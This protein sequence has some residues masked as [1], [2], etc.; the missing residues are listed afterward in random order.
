MDVV[1]VVTSPQLAGPRVPGQARQCPCDAAGQP[2]PTGPCDRV[3]APLDA[4]LAALA[5]LRRRG[6]PTGAVTVHGDRLTV[7]L[8]PGSAED[9]PDLL[10]WLGWG[11]LD[12]VLRA[13]RGCAAPPA[14][15]P[16]AAP[17]TAPPPPAVPPPVVVP[18]RRPAS[19][20]AALPPEHLPG[21]LDA[22][23]DACARAHLDRTLVS[24][25]PSRTP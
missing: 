5:R 8:A 16:A 3:D 11:H 14:L 12:G 9:V 6:R 17:R 4:G 20:D 18:H 24:R 15:L 19:A 10:R 7:R 21:L 25:W 22:L 1:P 13:R 2:G 23:A